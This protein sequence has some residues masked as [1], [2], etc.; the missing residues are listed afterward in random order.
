MNLNLMPKKFRYSIIYN[1]ITTELATDPIGWEEQSIGFQRS[2]D[3][4]NNIE[5]TIPLSFTKD[6]YRMLKSIFDVGGAFSKA[7]VRIDKRKNNWDKEQFYIYILDFR[8]YKDNFSSISISGLEDGLLSKYT[9][10]ADTEYEIGFENSASCL[11]FAGVDKEVEN[12]VQQGIGKAIYARVEIGGGR[13]LYHL[14]GE[15]AVRRYSNKILFVN[16]DGVPY[17]TMTF[18]AIATTTINLSIDVKFALECYYKFNVGT[19][20]ATAWRLIKHS[21]NFSTWSDISG[22]GLSP[23]HL[24]N[25][26]LYLDNINDISFPIEEGYLYSCMLIIDTGTNTDITWS[27]I[28]TMNI[29]SLTTSANSG[30]IISFTHEWLISKLIERIYF[31]A[32]LVYNVSHTDYFPILSCGNAIDWS[33]RYETTN[34]NI[35]VSLKN[36]LK[37]LDI[38]CCIGIDITGNIITISDRGTFYNKTKNK[39]L[40][41]NNITLSFD[42]SHC[43]NKIKVGWSTEDKYEDEVYPFNCKKVFEIQNSLADAEY[44][45][46]H[47]F[48]GEMYKIDK[49]LTDVKNNTTINISYTDLCV[50]A[51]IRPVLRAL[52]VM[53]IQSPYKTFDIGDIYLTSA[54]NQVGFNYYFLD[55]ESLNA[56][57]PTEFTM[58][59][60]LF[61][62]IN[63]RNTLYTINISFE[64]NSTVDMFYDDISK[65]LEFRTYPFVFYKYENFKISNNRRFGRYTL[66]GMVYI[67]GNVQTTF[68]FIIKN[69]NATRELSIQNFIFYFNE[70][71]GLYKDQTITGFIG[72]SVTAYNLPFSPKRIINKHL[73]YISISNWKN[74]LPIKFVSS[75]KES[76]I[77]STLAYESVSVTENADFDS[78]DPLFSP[79]KISFDTSEKFNSLS[80][81]DSDKYDYYEIEDERTGE[82]IKGWKNKTTHN[83][84]KNQAQ[85]WELQGSID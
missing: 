51:C 10:K 84:S 66:K 78:V 6:G 56:T 69:N 15:R 34:G 81:S 39:S 2:S 61:T 82:V 18:R 36:V 80:Q 13:A 25:Y 33:N 77:T 79:M 54:D 38:L 53:L 16:T 68:S 75:D 67:E 52:L 26:D 47:P 63:P 37:S 57:F 55:F 43:Y 3:Y 40:K 20:S 74:T 45:L 48:I 44:D 28:G 83:V 42:E 29:K 22:W 58:G 85:S 70:E 32:V 31:D 14:K 23:V 24:N 65:S 73:P 11:N 1:G 76:P 5:Y 72:D 4:G 30:S 8:T 59:D 21:E 19:P 7:K 62:F 49:F 35:K 12:I 60:G 9:S 71:Y 27:S 50:F 64:I 17:E 46:E 41:S